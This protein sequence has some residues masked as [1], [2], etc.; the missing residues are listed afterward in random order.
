MEFST[1]LQNEISLCA[2]ERNQ[3]QSDFQNKPVDAIY[4]SD[5]I[6]FLCVK[7]DVYKEVLSWVNSNLSL[8]EIK[9]RLSL[10]F[11]EKARH[12]P[13]ASTKSSQYQKMQILETKAQAQLLYDIT[14]IANQ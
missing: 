5:Y 14:L 1:Y 2:A 11:I 7:E 3:W 10:E 12:L 8:A 9:A 13:V 6:F 4:T